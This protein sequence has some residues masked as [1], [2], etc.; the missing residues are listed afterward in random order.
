[1][2]GQLADLHAD[3]VHRPLDLRLPRIEGCR[4]TLQCLHPRILRHLEIRKL[5]FPIIFRHGEAVVPLLIC[6]G[7]ALLPL[8]AGLSK[9]LLP[10]LTRLLDAR[11]QNIEALGKCIENEFSFRIHGSKAALKAGVVVVGEM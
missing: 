4:D 3:V 7:E 1:M 11:L 9:A 8:L 2:L 5:A 6:F 10:L